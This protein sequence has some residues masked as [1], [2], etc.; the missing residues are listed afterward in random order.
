M[1]AKQVSRYAQPINVVNM[2]RAEN[3]RKSRG[4]SRRGVLPALD[5]T[6]AAAMWDFRTVKAANSTDFVDSAQDN[7]S[8]LLFTLPPEIRLKI[9]ELV[10]GGQLLHIDFCRGTDHELK[11]CHK[12]CRTAISEETADHLF[13]TKTALPQS[14]KD[15]HDPCCIKRPNPTTI[16]PAFLATC[17][18]VYNEARH[19][20]YT[21]NTFSF[22]D[23]TTLHHFTRYLEF[24]G[25]GH[26][27]EVRRVH[28]SM[29]ADFF[30]N[31][32]SWK[33]TIK[34][35]LVPCFPKVQR[36]FLDLVQYYHGGVRGCRTPAEFE[37]RQ[38]SGSYFMSALLE[39]RKLPL[40]RATFVIRDLEAVGGTDSGVVP[41]PRW[42]VAEKQVWARYIK[43]FILQTEDQRALPSSIAEE[44]NT[45]AKTMELGIKS[46]GSEKDD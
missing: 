7:A 41:R 6:A 31:E 46:S 16:D 37:A 36:V 26:H 12:V 35:S 5:P 15:R 14:V 8:T 42:T 21:T 20:L 43:D 25:S 22:D 4:G 33:A 29:T 38:L 3:M 1:W 10:C 28:L 32:R 2:T 44:R 23:P 9:Y 27:L 11:F 40:T 30:G 19:I 17:R 34:Q 13:H 39:L 18:H 45:A 24:S